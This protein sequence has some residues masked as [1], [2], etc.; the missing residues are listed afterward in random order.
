L[1]KSKELEINNPRS[2]SE[3]PLSIKVGMEFKSFDSL[4]RIS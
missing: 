1:G 3:H 4:E 2:L